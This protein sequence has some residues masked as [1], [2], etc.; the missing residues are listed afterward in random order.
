QNLKRGIIANR[1]SQ[2]M[3][4]D[5]RKHVSGKSGAI[6]PSFR[7]GACRKGKLSDWKIVRQHGLFYID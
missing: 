4:L 2:L 6:Q 1:K 5:S 7:Y 3:Q